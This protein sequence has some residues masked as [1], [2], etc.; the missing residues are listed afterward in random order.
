MTPNENELEA[1]CARVAVLEADKAALSNLLETSINIGERAQARLSTALRAINY[2][3]SNSY[4]WG[5]FFEAFGLGAAGMALF[6][7]PIWGLIGIAVMIFGRALW[8]ASDYRWCED[9]T[10]DPT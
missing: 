1:L 6:L 9:S 5:L 10:D 8:E 4:F 2:Y 3:Q 7:S